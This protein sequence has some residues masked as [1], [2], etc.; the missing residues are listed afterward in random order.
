MNNSLINLSLVTSE[1]AQPHS[2]EQESESIASNYIDYIEQFGFGQNNSRQ[3]ETSTSN[4][5]M[6]SIIND[7]SNNN[8]TFNDDEERSMVVIE[9]FSLQEIKGEL[10]RILNF[11]SFQNM[12]VIKEEEESFASNKRILSMLDDDIKK[13]KEFRYDYDSDSKMV[14]I[15]KEKYYEK[16]QDEERTLRSFSFLNPHFKIVMYDIH[17]ERTFFVDKDGMMNSNKNTICKDIMF[18]RLNECDGIIPNDIIL[19]GDMS[20]SRLHC[21][22]V[23]KYYFTSSYIVNKKFLML[24]F[25]MKKVKKQSRLP[26]DVILLILEY[27]RPRRGLY[28]QDLNSNINTFKKLKD[29]ERYKLIPKSSVLIGYEAQFNV[30]SIK[31][32]DKPVISLPKNS[33]IETTNT[34]FIGFSEDK[35]NK[36]ILLSHKFIVFETKNCPDS[37]KPYIVLKAEE[38]RCYKI[39]RNNL[40]DISINLKDISRLH[41]KV[42]YTNGTWFI[43]DGK[44]NKHS[45]NGTWIGIDKGSKT[46]YKRG[47]VRLEEEDEF[48]VGSSIFKIIFN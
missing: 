43:E 21:K 10:S 44:D 26:F 41:C 3:Q 25:F 48:K 2:T 20:I 4:L 45:S 29:K 5:Q 40:T 6:Q 7:L 14:E 46:Y 39:G 23:T 33:N 34:L 16:I 8:F 36:E 15:R 30:I 17:K 42:Q 9:E 19:N 12:E 27:V 37:V 31:T 22:L 47:M 1:Q 38:N 32:S 24:L 35:I 18:G 13:T 28:L 11:V